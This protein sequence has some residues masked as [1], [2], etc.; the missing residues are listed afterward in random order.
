MQI[1]TRL[2][3]SQPRTL[4][5]SLCQALLATLVLEKAVEE[6]AQGSTLASRT[7]DIPELATSLRACK[8][9]CPVCHSLV[10]P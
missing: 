5:S 3:P 10:E 6:V 8:C 9:L 2:S 1:I 7:L 4:A